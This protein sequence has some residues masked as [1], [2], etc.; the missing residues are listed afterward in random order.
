MHK[1][2]KRK[3]ILKNSCEM[4]QRVAVQRRKKNGKAMSPFSTSAIYQ[5][6]KK[7]K[8]VLNTN[9]SCFIINEYLN[10]KMVMSPRLWRWR[11][12]A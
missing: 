2:H 5:R 1:I 8:K 3:E 7:S 6:E 9:F 4:S 11:E 12:G 10:T